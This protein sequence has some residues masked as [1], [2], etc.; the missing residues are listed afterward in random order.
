LSEAFHLIFA[1][2]SGRLMETSWLLA[3]MSQHFTVAEWTLGFVLEFL[4]Q[5]AN[6]HVS[7]AILY[8]LTCTNARCF[9]WPTVYASPRWSYLHWKFRHP[10]CSHWQY[11]LGESFCYHGLAIRSN[12]FLLKNCCLWGPIPGSTQMDHCCGL[13]AS[14]SY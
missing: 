10:P 6:D 14:S 5:G 11:V 7:I 4:G 1:N 12:T 9:S 13:G 8:T 3:P 2:R